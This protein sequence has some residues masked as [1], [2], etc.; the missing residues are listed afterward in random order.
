MTYWI[1]TKSGRVIAQ[2]TVQHITT[3]DMQQESIRQLMDV[4]N[5]SITACFADEH[6]IL[7]EPGLFYL[8]DMETPDPDYDP[9][10]PTEAKCG[11]MIQ[12]PRP[13]I[14]VDT[15]DRYLNAEVVVERDGEPTRARIVKRARLQNGT[16]IGRLHTNPL[17]DTREYDCIFDDGTTE[18]YTANIIAENLYSQ[19]DSEGR[20]FLVLKEIIDHEKD[21]SAI[22][23]SDGFTLSFNGHKVPKKTTRGWKLLCQWKDE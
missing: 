21:H 15:Y 4:F 12:E 20:S 16:P 7:L 14:D 19:C 9:N 11:D 13:D 3:T 17:F 18:R 5:T 22:P 8:E 1:L 10:I 2:S 23:I 6:F